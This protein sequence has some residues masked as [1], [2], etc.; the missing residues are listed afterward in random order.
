MQLSLLEIRFK[1][2]KGRVQQIRA[3]G[4]ERFSWPLPI[5]RSAVEEYSTLTDKPGA[6]YE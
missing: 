6:T 5:K 4:V 3:D 2:R 1:S